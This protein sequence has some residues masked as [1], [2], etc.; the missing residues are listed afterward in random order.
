[1]AKNAGLSKARDA[2]KDEFYTAYEDI[3]AEMNHYEEK[4]KGTT[5]LCNC[6][7]PFESNFCKFFL[8]NFNY[9]G[10]KR[11]MVLWEFLS[12]F[13]TSIIQSSLKS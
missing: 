9:L 5:V 11:L 12:H 1:M 6:D 13:L 4:F 2:K 7:D 3:Q 8:R 10:L